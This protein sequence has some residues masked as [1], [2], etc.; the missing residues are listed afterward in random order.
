MEKRILFVK[1]L[2]SSFIRRD[3]VLLAQHHRLKVFHFSQNKG[4]RVVFGLVRQFFVM[5]W[6]IPQSHL[7]YIWFADFHAVIPSI[8]GRAFR[9]KVVIII[10]GVDASYLPEYRYGTKTR[11]FGKLSVKLSTRLAT[12]LLPVSIFTKNALLT[13]ISPQLETKTRVIY[14][15]FDAPFLSADNEYRR[16][17]LTVCLASRVNTLYIK[18]VDFFIEVAR[19]LPE[20]SFSVVGPHGEAYN[21]L[22][23]TKPDNL[24]VI[25]PLSHDELQQTLLRSKIICQFSRHEAFGL[26]LLEGI[27]SGCFPIGYDFGGTAEILQQTQTTLLSKLDVEEAKSRLRFALSADAEM[28][29]TIQNQVLPRF[30]CALRQQQLRQIIYSD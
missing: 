4:W 13:N 22:M 5:L 20:L 14:N 24:N 19:A 23:Q 29:K 28:M 17:I 26:A 3:E 27:A 10:G 6:L 11:L 21:F 15:C 16:E 8:L 30:S 7:V 1:H 25:K 18:G 12:H 2:N 9:R